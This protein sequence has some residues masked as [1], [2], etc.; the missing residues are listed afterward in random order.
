MEDKREMEEEDSRLGNTRDWARR[1]D[2]GPE[3]RGTLAEFAEMVRPERETA[4]RETAE[5]NKHR[6]ATEMREALV[7]YGM[8]T[9]F[10]DEPRPP[11]SKVATQREV[12]RDVLLSASQCGAWLTMAEMH[13]LTRFAIPSIAAN[14][15]AMRPSDGGGWM[16]EK[17]LRKA[18]AT[19]DGG[20][21]R[22]VWEYRMEAPAG[23]DVRPAQGQ[24]F[25]DYAGWHRG[26]NRAEPE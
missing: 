25:E 13:K 15:R 19:L 17:R 5:K 12:L 26:K 2:R 14:V 8:G 22:E 3:K 18:E 20:A 24:N 1:N 9:T 21:A 10:T 11:E 23:I 4:E 16:I 7:A 6:D